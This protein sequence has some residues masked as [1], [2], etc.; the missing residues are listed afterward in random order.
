M[1]GKLQGAFGFDRLSKVNQT[2]EDV[3]PYKPKK[4]NYS[5]P[6]FL[7]LNDDEVQVCQDVYTRPIILPRDEML[8]PRTSGY[9]EVINAGKSKNNE[10][11]ATSKLFFIK[12]KS[13]NNGTVQQEIPLTS[14]T[15]EEPMTEIAVT[16]FGIFDGHAGA[17]AAVMT[18]KLLHEQIEEKL[19]GVKDFIFE[20]AGPT[21]EPLGNSASDSKSI[22]IH[23]LIIG[24]LEQAFISMDRQIEHDKQTYSIFGGCAVIVALFLLGKLYVA[25]AGDCRAIFCNKKIHVQLSNDMTPHNERRRIMIQAMTRPELM[26]GEFTYNEYNRR[27]VRNDIGKRILYRGPVM[28]GWSYKKAE[29]DDLKI[30]LIYKLGGKSRLMQTIGVTRG[31]GDHDLRVY[32]SSIYLKPFLSPV[33]EVKV[34]DLKFNVE[35]SVLVMASDG[36]WDVLSAEDVQTSVFTVLNQYRKDDPKRFNG[37]AQELV[38]QARGTPAKCGHGWTKKDGTQG[39]F[40]DI[41]VFV[42]PLGD[43]I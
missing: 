11:Q 37:V 10:D 14:L 27:I 29:E 30:P 40:D 31:F 25:N 20:I 15:D 5:R 24:A 16:Y 35:E 21:K 43:T 4:F 19:N 18:S 7:Q 38:M 39:S 42:I 33:P 17:D 3:A 13:V 6:E 26:G 28:T 23:S 34:F 12:K 32:D 36:L 8:L 9:A 41:T 22:S 2:G 1:W